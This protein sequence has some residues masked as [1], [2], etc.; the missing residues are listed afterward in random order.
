M[1][2]KFCPARNKLIQ[3]IAK[4]ATADPVLAPLDK[5]KQYRYVIRDLNKAIFPKKAVMF[6]RHYMKLAKLKPRH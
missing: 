5:D 4:R 6:Q 1:K 3:E 2:E